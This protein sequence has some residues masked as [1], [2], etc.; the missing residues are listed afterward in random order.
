M[1]ILLIFFHELHNSAI[2]GNSIQDNKTKIKDLPDLP[3]NCKHTV[4]FWRKNASFLIVQSYRN[5]V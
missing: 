4:A 3:D 1:N 5:F 2:N